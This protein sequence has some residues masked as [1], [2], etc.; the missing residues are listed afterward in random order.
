MEIESLIEKSA[1]NREKNIKK[2][3]KVIDKLLADNSLSAEVIG[4]PKHNYSIY[5]KIINFNNS[6]NQNL[7]YKISSC[8]MST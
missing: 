6:S 7:F 2:S 8:K 5:K 3:V 4:R 1:P